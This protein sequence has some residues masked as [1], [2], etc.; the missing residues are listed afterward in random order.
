[1]PEKRIFTQEMIDD[2]YKIGDQEYCKK[3]NI[4]RPT[5]MKYRYAN[6]IKPFIPQCGTKPHKLENGIEYKWC[7]FGHWEPI[8]NFFH[9]KTNYDNVQRQC[10]VH[11]M[12]K[13]YKYLEKKRGPNWKPK[14]VGIEH[15]F[16]DGI[17]CKWCPSGKH[18]VS[19]N[20]FYKCSTRYDGVGGIC[21]EHIKK[22]VKIYNS[23]EEHRKKIR[24]Y[25]KTPSGRESQRRLW[26]RKKAEKEDAYVSWLKKDEHFAYDLFDH[27]CAYCG[28]QLDF[29]TLEFD[30]FI[31]IKMGGKT[32]P[33]NM[34]PCCYVCNHGD[35]G[36]FAKDAL[37][38]LTEKFGERAAILIYQDVK[39]KLRLARKVESITEERINV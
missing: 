21:I 28:F 18:W 31:P 1:M 27:Q 34:V 3:W 29:L 7:Y 9:C 5:I 32:E 19:L 39:K 23:A 11:S 8:E 36:K 13:H 35:G 22:T 10:K 24:E 30:H 15:K 17:E 38:W 2:L 6:E 25:K 16:I 4:S 33:G 37:E 26:R 12:E 20:G 14:F